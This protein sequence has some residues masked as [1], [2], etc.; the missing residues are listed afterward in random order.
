MSHFCPQKVKVD[1]IYG[2]PSEAAN[3]SGCWRKPKLH[4]FEYNYLPNMHRLTRANAKAIY[5]A[6]VENGLPSSIVWFI[7]SKWFN[8]TKRQ[9]PDCIKINYYVFYTNSICVLCVKPP[10]EPWTETS[11]LVNLWAH[12]HVRWVI[13]VS[14]HD[15]FGLSFWNESVFFFDNLFGHADL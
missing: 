14:F 15:L 8:A 2:M 9:S 1:Q 4:R 6:N 10:D 13:A 3:Y 11:K 7:A 5:R 12:F